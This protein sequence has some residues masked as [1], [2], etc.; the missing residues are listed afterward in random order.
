MTAT[1]SDIAR[2]LG[3]SVVTVS[4]VL[5]NKGNISPATRKR[6]LKRA[7]K[8]HYQINWIARSLKTRRTYMIGLLL[9]DITHPFFADVAKAAA[10]AA[11]SRGYHVL[12]SYFEENPDLEQKEAD[13]L[14]SRQIDG[15]IVAS[16]QS[17][18]E[19]FNRIKKRGVPVV[20]IDRPVPGAKVDFVG[21]N[22]AIIGRMATTHLIKQG[23]VR[24]AHLRGSGTS[25]SESR[26]SGFT[27]ALKRNR[28]K[29]NPAYVI[30]AGFL[31]GDGFNA[32]R[33]LLQL[34]PIPDGVFCYNDPVAIGA[35]QAILDHGLRVPQDI[36]VI[37]A[38][39]VRYTDI[40]SVPLTTIDQD[41]TA[42]GR[43]AAELL[44]D[45]IESKKRFR[46]VSILTEPQLMVRESTQ[47]QNKRR[48]LRAKSRTKSKGFIPA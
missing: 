3:V 33:Q 28:M 24:I 36:A 27:A 39:N 32:M 1:M 12:I 31:F 37:G 8:L 34:N 35:I 25:V 40:I 22:N 14:V 23:C 43:K 21:C 19:L 48:P 2:D 42:L 30:R 9:P 5:R 6:V 47:R 26:Y 44:I 41:T 16:A 11:M 7:K 38:G 15:L 13:F 46:P 10:A 20:L 18:P 17:K 4:K 45:R 29:L